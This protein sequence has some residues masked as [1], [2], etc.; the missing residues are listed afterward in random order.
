MAITY[1]QMTYGQMTR[2]KFA[3]VH[4]DTYSSH[5]V[6][7]VFEYITK[8]SGI[9]AEI[10]V[11]RALTAEEQ[12]DTHTKIAKFPEWDCKEPTLDTLKTMVGRLHGMA[13]KLYRKKYVGDVEDYKPPVVD[14]RK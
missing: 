12:G 11:D 2:G 5:S 13:L 14:W 3:S 9:L 7:T 4:V 6:F 8:N 1:S 10:K